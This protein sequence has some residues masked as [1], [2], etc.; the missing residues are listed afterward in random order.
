MYTAVT[1]ILRLFPYIHGKY[2][3]QRNGDI[4]QLAES[5][6]VQNCPLVYIHSNICSHI[7]HHISSL[8]WVFVSALYQGNYRELI[9]LVLLINK[10]NFAQ[11]LI[12]L[13]LE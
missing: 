12:L 10:K 9:L 2:Y 8:L 7:G 6:S 1:G 11:G 3:G 5:G 4:D 13:L